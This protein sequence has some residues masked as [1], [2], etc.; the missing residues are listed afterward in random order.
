ML[1]R[2]IQS[3]FGRYLRACRLQTG[4]SLDEVA[5]QTKITISCLQR[6]ENQSLHR[7]PQ[8]V[9]VKGLLKS[10]AQ[11]VGGD[12]DEA[13]RRYRN[14][15]G[16]R[17]QS[18]RKAEPTSVGI[19]SPWHFLVALLLLG[20]TAVGAL[21]GVQMV[22]SQDSAPGPLDGLQNESDDQRTPEEKAALGHIATGSSPQGA[23]PTALELTA[24]AVADTRLKIIADGWLPQ[25]F[26]LQAGEQ[27][28]VT[29]KARLSMLI[30]NAGGVR[31]SLNGQHI[32]VPGKDGQIVTLD[33]PQ[34]R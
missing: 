7:L 5:A 17:Q 23:G 20:L 8:D 3:D 1:C 22:N 28:V 21:Y 9:F 26:A 16:M 29:A 2:E 13:L 10:F 33:L 34:T 4:R 15:R 32:N 25:E 31:L 30:V 18:G 24:T 12:A 27:I 11:A 14:C 19:N 6:I